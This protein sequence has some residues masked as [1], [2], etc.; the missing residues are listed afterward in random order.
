MADAAVEAGEQGGGLV[1]DDGG[2]E[3]GTGEVAD[4]FEGTPGGLDHDFDFA[5]EAANGNHGSEVA[6]DAAKLGQNI[7]G[8]VLQIFRQL[9]FGGASGPAA[10]DGFGRPGRRTRGGG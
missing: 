3:V 8:K 2:F 9:R 10:Q 1:G 6:G 4:R 7:F 5:I